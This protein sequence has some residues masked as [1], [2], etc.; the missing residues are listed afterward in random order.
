VHDRPIRRSSYVE[1]GFDNDT[2]IEWSEEDVVFLHWRLLQ[3]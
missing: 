2:P 1:L 3:K